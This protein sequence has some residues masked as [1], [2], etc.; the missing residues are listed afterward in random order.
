MPSSSEIVDVFG[1]IGFDPGAP[2]HTGETTAVGRQRLQSEGFQVN[3]RTR[4]V[5][6]AEGDDVILE[7]SPGGG[8]A[9]KGSTVTITVGKFNASTAPGASTTGGA[10]P[11]P[12]TTTP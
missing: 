5:D 10:T 11:G 7:Q 4:Q 9:P 12:T 1:Q 2:W 3:Q 6:S 8:K